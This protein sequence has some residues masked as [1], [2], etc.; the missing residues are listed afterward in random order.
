[1]D[2]HNIFG[3]TLE[4]IPRD[5]VKAVV[6][7]LTGRWKPCEACSMATAHRHY[8]PKSTDKRAAVQAGMCFC[9]SDIAD[10]GG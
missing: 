7:E 8:V 1:M 5:T 10:E 4:T 9:G 3:P 6:I 2:M